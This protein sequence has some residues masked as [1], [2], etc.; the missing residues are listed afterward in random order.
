MRTVVYIPL[1]Y[2]SK[3]TLQDLDTLVT[4]YIISLGLLISCLVKS[5]VEG[6]KIIQM[7]N[8]YSEL[9]GL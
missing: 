6:G 2:I 5:E 7:T 3:T 1:F 9:L 8:T 4:Y